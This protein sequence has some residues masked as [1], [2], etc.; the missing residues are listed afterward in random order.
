M[1]NHDAKFLLQA[2]RPGGDDSSDPQMAVALEQARR[3]PELGAWLAAEQGFGTLVTEKLR[4]VTPPAGLREAILA[5]GRVSGPTQTTQA[6]WRG[7]Q[8]RWLGL[9]A[10]VTLAALMAITVRPRAAGEAGLGG[11]AQAALREAR[12]AHGTPVHAELLG[13][14][15]AWVQNPAT[16][17]AA[18]LP[19]ELASIG[20]KGCRSISVGGH[21]VF[22]V[23]FLR[24]GA[25]YHFY[26]GR[27]GD[28]NIPAGGDSPMVVAQGGMATVT[29]ADARNVYVVAG[30]GDGEALKAFL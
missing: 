13:E 30:A 16:K 17:L 23:C 22:E 11:L 8:A 7:A 29:W 15:G 3:D 21:E 25:W 10:A 27:R 14:F 20:A 4:A 19:V 18:G 24:G 28:F 12:G 26:V 2:Y 1:K 5:G 6:W 9:A